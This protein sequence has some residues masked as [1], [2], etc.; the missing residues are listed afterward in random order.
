MIREEDFP[1]EC[2]IEGAREEETIILEVIEDIGNI[3]INGNGNKNNY[4]G[5]VIIIELFDFCFWMKF[6]NYL[7]H[8][9]IFF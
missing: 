7:L 5:L 3:N 4:Y 1:E 9:L 6:N 8:Y 2:R